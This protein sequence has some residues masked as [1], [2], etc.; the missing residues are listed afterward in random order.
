MGLTTTVL[1]IRGVPMFLPISIQ[2][3]NR[4]S[5]LPAGEYAATCAIYASMDTSS[6]V[7]KFEY[8]RAGSAYASACDILLIDGSGTARMCDF[9]RMPDRS[10]RDSF[11]ARS[12]SL[13]DLLPAEISDYQFVEEK[14]LAARIVENAHAR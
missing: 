13:L 5:E 11:G 6:T 9:L 2:S 12:D 1:S 10:W 7:M 8:T 14:Q 4:A 3:V